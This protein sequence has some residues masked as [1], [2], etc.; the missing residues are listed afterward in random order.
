MSDE[1]VSKEQMIMNLLQ[2]K[3]ELVQQLSNHNL[4]V[5]VQDMISKIDS[6]LT[7][8]SSNIKK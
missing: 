7:K 2:L 1:F 4:A 5:N 8:V 3:A 6:C